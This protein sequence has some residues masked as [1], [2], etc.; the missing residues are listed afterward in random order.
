MDTS[1]R[2]EAIVPLAMVGILILLPLVFAASPLKTR[3]AGR[4]AAVCLGISAAFLVFAAFLFDMLLGVSASWFFTL[5]VW[6]FGLVICLAVRM[7]HQS[8]FALVTL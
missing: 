7:R 6:I 4:V 5:G 8:D 2:T 1:V 3:F